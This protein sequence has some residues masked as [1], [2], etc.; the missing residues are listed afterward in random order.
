MAAPALGIAGG[1]V[2]ALGNYFD[3]LQ[4]QA[5]TAAR[6]Q[7]DQY[8]AK[9]AN[10][11]ANVAM[12]NA[13]SKSN[14]MAIHNRAT[15]GTMRAAAIE[16]G[17]TL[18]GSLGEVM[19]ESAFNMEMDRLNTVYGGEL[20]AYSYKSKAA[21]DTWDA[22]IAKAYEPTEVTNTVLKGVGSMIGAGSNAYGAT[23]RWDRRYNPDD[24]E[25]SF[26]GGY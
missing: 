21:M 10:D 2:S 9:I 3:I 8:N 4:I 26:F 22:Q 23:Q 5:Q 20:E 12:A 18:Q 16:S 17:Q 7:A 11:Q 14:L 24:T 19:D 6:V 1:V 25:N 13:T 15:M